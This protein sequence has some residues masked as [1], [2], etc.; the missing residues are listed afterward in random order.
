[1]VLGRTEAAQRGGPPGPPPPGPATSGIQKGI[2]MARNTRTQSNATTAPVVEASATP[3][4]ETPAKQEAS[5]FAYLATKSPSDLHVRLAEFIL[6]E[7]P[8][9]EISAKQVQLVL[10]LHGTFQSSDAN[11]KRNAEAKAK[12]E[13]ARKAR[14]AAAKAKLIEQAKKMGLQVG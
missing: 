3:V 12:A 7:V 11:K 9:V 1:M 13:K 8:G 5:K 6:A 2:T 4:V 10:G 14:E